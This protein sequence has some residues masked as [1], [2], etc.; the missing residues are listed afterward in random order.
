MDDFFNVGENAALLCVDL[1]KCY[2]RLPINQLFPKLEE[3]VTKVLAFIRYILGVL[4]LQNIL[5]II[6]G[7]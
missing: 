2:Y 4:G 6:N 1:Q 7:N 3:N 5:S